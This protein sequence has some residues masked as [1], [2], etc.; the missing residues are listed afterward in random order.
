MLD[1]ITVTVTISQLCPC[2]DFII[3]LT[4][5]FRRTI[6]FLGFTAALT[7]SAPLFLLTAVLAAVFELVYNVTNARAYWDSVSEYGYGASEHSDDI[8]NIDYIS[9]LDLT[10]PSSHQD[11]RVSSPRLTYKYFSPNMAGRELNTES[12]ETNPSRASVKYR[13]DYRDS[14][15]YLLGLPPNSVLF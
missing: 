5:W 1:P 13:G 11:R 4:T 2:Q 10:G 14:L 12:S 9:R 7:A 15:N 6:W 3:E 8:G